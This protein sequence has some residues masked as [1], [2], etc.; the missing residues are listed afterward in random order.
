MLGSLSVFADARHRS[1]VWAVDV[2]CGHSSPSCVVVGGC[3]LRVA[4]VGAV[5]ACRPEVRSLF[6]WWGL[7]GIV[8]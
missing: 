2:V 3:R 7:F 4:L 6:R 1:W 8:W 5:F